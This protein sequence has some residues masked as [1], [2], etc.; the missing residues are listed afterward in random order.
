MAD[1]KVSFPGTVDQIETTA[2]KV[3]VITENSTENEYPSAKAVYSMAADFPVE[4]GTDGI[5]TWRKWKSGIA[6]C[7]GKQ[8]VSF[9]N[10]NGAVGSVYM[11]NVAGVDFPA[12]I[13]FTDIPVVTKNIRNI[14]GGYA[15]MGEFPTDITTTNTGA[16]SF[17]RATAA[18]SDAEPWPFEFYID[19]SVK[20]IWK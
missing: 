7:W 19:Y 20:G 14:S 17:W 8:R 3:N 13:G 2:N 18:G 5:W 4:Q 12:D 15:W 11:N 6:E 1:Q 10:I 16:T 9:N